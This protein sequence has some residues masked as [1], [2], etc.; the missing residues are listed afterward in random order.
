MMKLM[1]M[2]M[3]IYEKSDSKNKKTILKT[4][5]LNENY[6]QFSDFNTLYDIFKNQKSLITK[7]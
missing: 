5:M 4:L 3:N 2:M 1:M 7:N 6:L